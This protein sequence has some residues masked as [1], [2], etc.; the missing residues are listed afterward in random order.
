[1]RLR[2]PELGGNLPWRTEDSEKGHLYIFEKQER[3]SD[4]YGQ[5]KLHTSRF[6]VTV[7]KTA[8]IAISEF[9]VLKGFPA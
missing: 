3:S 6:Q 9:P 2:H 7:R 1:M 8:L 4:P 5:R